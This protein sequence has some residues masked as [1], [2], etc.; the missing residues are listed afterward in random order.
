[1]D[2]FAF[3]E[4]FEFENPVQLESMNNRIA[5][6]TE[7]V[8]NT[9]GFEFENPLQP[10]SMNNRIAD[11]MEYV[12][13][14]C[15][16][17][18]PS[19]ISNIRVHE[20]ENIRHDNLENDSDTRGSDLRKRDRKHENKSYRPL[21]STKA[22]DPPKD[23]GGQKLKDSP[24]NDIGEMK[25][26]HDLYEDMDGKALWE[27]FCSC[28]YL[29]FRN[30]LNEEKITK[31]NIRIRSS[32]KEMAIIDDEGD[33]IGK[34]KGGVLDISHGTFISGQNVDT[35]PEC[36][37]QWLKIG[38]SKELKTVM[39]DGINAVHNLLCIY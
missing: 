33:M 14:T 18:S 22:F 29:Y 36:E 20:R 11:K 6:E 2:Y 21:K 38:Q 25:D 23:L 31:A 7:Y 37:R 13:N 1:M 24:C 15:K 16:E 30:V 3:L 5:D 19:R 27:R 34:K 12:S 9:C 4:G 28:G 26:S 8:S 32:L 39:N 10:D 17:S 35:G